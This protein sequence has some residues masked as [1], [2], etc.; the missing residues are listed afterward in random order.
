M[1][2]FFEADQGLLE[3]PFNCAFGSVKNYYFVVQR[4]RVHK[5]YTQSYSFNVH[6][7]SKYQNGLEA[8]ED[9]SPVSPQ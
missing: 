4:V 6:C 3:G 7:E 5:I 9:F 2:S 1:Q 8:V